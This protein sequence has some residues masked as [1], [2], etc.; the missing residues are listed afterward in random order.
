MGG[1]NALAAEVV[2]ALHDDVRPDR[3]GQPVHGPSRA[4]A[5]DAVRRPP[6]HAVPVHA[7]DR[8]RTALRLHVVAGFAG[9]DQGG[10]VNR[11]DKRSLAPSSLQARPL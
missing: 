2:V 7:P 10:T 11:A 1:A 4:E 3:L 8:V 5:E 6:A 9:H